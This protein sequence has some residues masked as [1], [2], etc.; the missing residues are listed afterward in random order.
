L[1][2]SKLSFTDGNVHGMLDVAIA[3]GGHR[4]RTDLRPPRGP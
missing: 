4:T 1:L 2:K 3:Y